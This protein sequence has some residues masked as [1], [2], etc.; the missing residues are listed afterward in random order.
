L[1]L[2]EF[3]ILKPSQPVESSILKSKPAKR[4]EKKSQSTRGIIEIAHDSMENSIL[5]NP[6]DENTF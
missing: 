2:N 3:I 6:I 4:R 1:K 5:G